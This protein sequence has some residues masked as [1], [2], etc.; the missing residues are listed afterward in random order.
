MVILKLF[1]RLL[2]IDDIRYKWCVRL[3]FFFCVILRCAAFLNP[4]SDTD[5]SG[6]YS[7]MNNLESNFTDQG[8]VAIPFTTGNIVFLVMIFSALFFTLMMGILYSGLFVRA[9]RIKRI[10]KEGPDV[11][12][13][14]KPL[15]IGKIF[16]R[17]IL[18]ALFY[19]AVS[20]PFLLI[21]SN[22]LLFVVIGFP[23]VFTAPCCYLSGDKGMFSSLPYVARITRG[24]YLAHVRS[25]II[26][27]LTFFFIDA[28][29]GLV[30]FASVT[31]FYILSAAFTTWI[32]FAFGRYAGM[33]Y[34]A[35]RD[36]NERPVTNTEKESKIG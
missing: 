31:V 16:K 34:C 35:M 8:M 19:L 25:L 17:L 2:N 21:S 5:F 27:V 33:A 36:A 28:L 20:I 1:E 3:M 9:F 22:L 15:P 18:L 26:L 32:T 24:F 11:L 4:Y 7:W 14:D 23:I 10:E 30:S 13:Q 12:F 6:L 29:A